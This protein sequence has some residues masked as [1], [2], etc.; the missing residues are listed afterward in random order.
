M[1]EHLHTIDLHDQE[2]MHVPTRALL[3]TRKVWRSLN[4]MHLKPNRVKVAQGPALVLRRE[5]VK[6]ARESNVFVRR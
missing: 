3:P 2:K 4:C 6:T 1:D 5:E